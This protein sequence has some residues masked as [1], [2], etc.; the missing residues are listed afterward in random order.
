MSEEPVQFH[1]IGAGSFATVFVFSPRANIAYKQLAHNGEFKAAEFDRDHKTHQAVFKAA[2]EGSSPATPLPNQPLSLA[3]FRVPRPGQFFSNPQ[4]VLNYLD[5]DDPGP[6]K[7][8]LPLYAMRRLFPIPPNLAKSIRNNFF[9][10]KY[11]SDKRGFIGRVY[12]GKLADSRSG[13]SGA[14]KLIFNSNNFPLYPSRMQALG[15]DVD[16]LAASMGKILARIVHHGGFDPRDI[17]FVLGSGDQNFADD[18]GLF[19]IDFNQVTKHNGDMEQVAHSITINDPYFP[20]PAMNGWNK[21]AE[22]YVS[23]AAEL[24][25]EAE[26]REPFKILEKKWKKDSKDV[27]ESGKET[28][29]IG[30]TSE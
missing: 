7:P 20:R 10:S 26:A 11:R 27:Q 8:D 1:R 5:H 17:E 12:L 18:A 29:E 15:F 9:P 28:G 23:V 2:H 25:A 3:E 13:D 14:P 19:V 4:A 22:S 30:G 16:S 24:G 21:F 6:L